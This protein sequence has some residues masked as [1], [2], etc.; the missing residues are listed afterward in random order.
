MAPRQRSPRYPV[1]D[2]ETALELL[3]KLYSKV[4]RGQFLP[5]DAASAWGYSSVSGQTRSKIAA[6]R[7]YGL[8]EGK[9]GGRGAESPKLSLR[10]LTLARRGPT[11]TGN[12]YWSELQRA[13]LTPPI[14]EELFDVHDATDE[15]L[16]HR[17]VVSREFTEEGAKRCIE[18]FRATARFSKLGD[19][20]FLSSLNIDPAGPNRVEEARTVHP[21]PEIESEG[22]HPG[23]MKIMLSAEDDDHAW[24]KRKMT[25]DEWELRIALFQAYRPAIV[26]DEKKTPDSVSKEPTPQPDDTLGLE[27]AM[28]AEGATRPGRPRF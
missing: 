10:G 15:W 17:L 21:E 26:R 23:M 18:G 11:A 22:S 4:G 5:S 14:F 27:G 28:P 1:V 16:Q 12:E 13:A 9:T 20:K 3:R 19:S 24:V 2:L 6:L 25:S 7:Q 8:I